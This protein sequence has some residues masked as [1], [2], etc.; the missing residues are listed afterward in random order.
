M[1]RHRPHWRIGRATYWVFTHDCHELRYVPHSDGKGIGHLTYPR[2]GFGSHV[3]PGL[4]KRFARRRRILATRNCR[5]IVRGT[6]IIGGR[7]R[8][9]YSGR[10]SAVR[11]YVDSGDMPQG[12]PKLSD[13]E[14]SE[15]GT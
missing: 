14:I 12:G 11:Q 4:V 2:Q 5:G 8:Q 6:E 1:L 10:C 9:K 7:L 13:A 3:T 15:I